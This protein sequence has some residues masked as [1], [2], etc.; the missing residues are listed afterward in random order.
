MRLKRKIGPFV[1]GVSIGLLLGVGFFIFKINDWFVK[2][3]DSANKQITVF[4]QP[5]KTVKEEEPKV[6]KAPREKFKVKLADSKP[7]NYNEVDKLLKEDAQITIATDELLSVKNVK[8]IKVSDNSAVTDSAA[9]LAEVDE[10]EP[11]IVQV[12]FWKTPL[13]SRGY[14][15]SKNK[16]LLYGF[17]DF[18][19]VLVYQY[20]HDYYLRSSDQV[21]RLSYTGDFR[22]PEKVTDQRLITKLN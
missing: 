6:K 22:A 16:V 12:E 11:E 21:Y 13:N 19:N 7:V 9:V 2:L 5:V 15:F 4:E 18:S 14:K 20:E 1:F 10:Q 17:P 8:V 3:R